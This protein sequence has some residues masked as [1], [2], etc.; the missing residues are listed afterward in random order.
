MKYG[1]STRLFSGEY[2]GSALLDRIIESG[3]REIEIY[4][5]R[6]HFDYHDRQ[7][8]RDIGLWFRDRGVGLES[9]HAPPFSE[10]GSGRRGGFV[11]SIAH[12]E[13]R[14]RIDSM[15]EIKRV[16][17]AAEQLPFRFL[18]LHLGLDEEE[19]SLEKFDAAFTSLEHLRIFA[20][21]RGV[22]L[23]LENTGGGMGTPSR[24]IDFLKY[25]RL[26]D[27]GICFDTGHAHLEGALA[28][29][30]N[31]VR[32][33]M[34]CAH[35]HDNAG[36]K[37]DHRMPFAGGVDWAA[38]LPALAGAAAG[39]DGFCALLELRERAAEPV[40]LQNLRATARQLEALERE[41]VEE[42]QG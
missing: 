7:R 12:L 4:A 26:D 31:T 22:K 9:V 41:P 14:H 34:V 24:L 10:P 38:F 29:S 28:E 25:T 21:E 16:L 23:L 30:L 3:F 15:D 42:N 17:E 20:K 36:E 2:L 6:E 19:F 5:A 35:L 27:V 8:V 11:I 39:I 33:R 18:I 1:L 13:R 40:T 32:A 37:D